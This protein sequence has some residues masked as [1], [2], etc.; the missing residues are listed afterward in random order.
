M[1]D[2][3]IGSNITIEGD[4]T[5]NEPLIIEGVVRGT[6]AVKGAVTVTQDGLVE[7]SVDSQSIEIAGSVQGNVSAVDK[8]DIKAGG[9]LI[10]DVRAP[11]VLI[12]DGAAFKGNIN[13]QS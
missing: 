1:A 11:R 9:R 2:T 4:I 6:V 7:A 8:I 3:I 12:A 5:G 10:G 13:M